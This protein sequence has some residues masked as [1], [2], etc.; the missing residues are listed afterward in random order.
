MPK[1]KKQDNTKQNHVEHE[2]P[3][4]LLRLH[5]PRDYARALQIQRLGGEQD[6]PVLSCAAALGLTWQAGPNPG[7]PR[8]S[9]VQ[10]KGAY[11]YGEIVL[12]ELIGK[13]WTLSDVV[14]G[15]RAALP[16]IADMIAD[17]VSEDE[18]KAAEGFSEA[19]EV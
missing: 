9:W 13:G 3:A 6:Q 4:G 1:K 14:A 2:C 11:R 18:V 16:L 8:A 5:R 19:G 10:C 12:N 7:Q 15:G 17:M